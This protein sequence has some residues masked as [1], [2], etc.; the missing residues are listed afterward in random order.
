M[1]WLETAL[2]CF[3]GLMTLA[4]AMAKHH[5]AVLGTAPGPSRG[6]A[7]P[8]L[9]RRLGGSPA[10]PRRLNGRPGGGAAAAAV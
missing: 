8:D 1:I 4:L 7:A 2:P 10:A 5:R 9:A 3:A 6:R